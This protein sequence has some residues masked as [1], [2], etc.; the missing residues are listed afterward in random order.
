VLPLLVALALEVHATGACPVAADVERQLGPLLADG[1]DAHDVA[2]IKP[3]ADG[4]VSLALADANGQPIGARTLPRAR[5]CDDQARAVAVTLAVLEAELHPQVAL[6]LDRLVPEP[7]PAAVVVARPAPTPARARELSL[8]AGA[9]VDRQAGGWAPGGRFEL[10]LGTLGARWRARVAAAAVGRHAV[11]VTPGQA[12]WWR[13]FV[14]VG[15]DVDVAR[16]RRSAFTLG[17]GATGGLVSIAG[18]GFAVDRSTRSFDVGAEARARL[19]MRAGRAGFWL[20]A[21]VEGWLRRQSLDLNGA[22]TGTALPR[23]APVA[24]A[25]AEIFW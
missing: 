9:F 18:S 1:A 12:S 16:G 8:G 14:Q 7:Q 25:G 22:S 4:S 23:V 21:A 10:A 19:T 11:D 13:G 17:A 5:S 3:G 2:T 24:A 20:G 6:G 15:A